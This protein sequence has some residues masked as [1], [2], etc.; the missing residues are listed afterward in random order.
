[1]LRTPTPPHPTPPHPTRYLQVPATALQ[2]AAKDRQ[3]RELQEEN[4]LLRQ[5]V[6]EMEKALQM[7]SDY[8]SATQAAHKVRG[9]D[10]DSGG[11]PWMAASLVYTVLFANCS[12]EDKRCCSSV[13][14]CLSASVLNS[15]SSYAPA[16]CP[17]P[18]RAL[19]STHRSSRCLCMRV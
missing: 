6:S 14:N 7:A 1:V 2:L 8:H 11:C 12:V 13:P 4:C 3:V 18:L 19:P 9:R 17:P 5:Q 10:T 16:L 15:P